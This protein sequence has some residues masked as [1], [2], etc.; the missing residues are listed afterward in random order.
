MIEALVDEEMVA[1]DREMA[2]V[3]GTDHPFLQELNARTMAKPGKR[4]RPKLLV[5]CSKMVGHEGDLAV[6]YSAVFE[7]IH[8]ATLIHDDIIDEAKT[9]RGQETLNRDLGNTLTVLYGDLL[10]TKAH[11]SAIEAGNFEIMHIIT[12]V[13]ERMIEGE[14]LQNKVNYDADIDEA[15][16]FDILKRKT[17]YLF[18]GTTKSAG[19]IQGCTDAQVEALFQF[20]FHFG[21]SFQLIDDYLDYTADEAKLGKPVM[22]DLYEGKVTL[23]IIKLLE[24]DDGTLKQAIRDFWASKEKRVPQDLLDRLRAEDGLSFT[25]ERA[26]FYAEK[27]VEQLADFPSNIYTEVLRALPIKLLDRMH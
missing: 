16:Y 12:S 21:T 8:N 13:S 27:A 18:A 15:T 5:L 24:G 14:L 23:P 1:L 22:Q 17:A 10:Y 11:T 26:R 6:R 7:L 3:L 19:L 20:G 4:L 9:R 25:R 2:R